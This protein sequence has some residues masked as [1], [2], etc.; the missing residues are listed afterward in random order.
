MRGYFEPYRIGGM[1]LKNRIVMAP[2]TRRRATT[3]HVPVPIMAEYYKQR[4]SAGLIISEASP[5]SEEAVGYMNIPGIFNQKQAE[6]WKPVTEAV[7]AKNGLIFIQLWHVGRISHPLLQPGGALP[8]SASAIGTDDLINTPNGHQKMVTPRALETWEIPRL[9][10]EYRNAAIRAIDAGFDGVE[11]H[12]ANSYLL[13]QFLHDSS[14]F[15]TDVYGGPAANRCRLVLEVVE[16][17]SA[18][19]GANKT[20]IRLSPSNIKYGIDDSD[21]VGLYEYLIS[22]LDLFNLAYL[23]LA[24]PMMPLDNYPHMIKD[25]TRHFRKFWSGPLITCGNYTNEKGLAVLESG[26][27][28]L[29]AFGRLFIS[30]PDLPMRFRLGA[31]LIQPDINTFYYGGVKGY[32]D[33]PSLTSAH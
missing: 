11:I 28:D 33:Y 1:I 23:H 18:A 4:A 26:D 8:V 13:E 32:T 21:P 24:E 10:E 30:N 12:S 7:H 19:I 9:I 17:V 14:N 20:G 3:D 5:I 15:R 25:V 29:V 16:A 6:A 27:A 22:K 31:E 2:L